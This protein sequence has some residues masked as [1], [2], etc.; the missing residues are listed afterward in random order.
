VTIYVGDQISNFVII[1]LVLGL[2]L[3]RRLLSV[4]RG[5]RCGIA[6]V[7]DTEIVCP[8]TGVKSYD[9][10]F[11]LSVEDK[12]IDVTVK[13]FPLHIYPDA[14][15]AHSKVQALS[16][17][18]NICTI[19]G[20]EVEA[21]VLVVAMKPTKT[22]LSE[23]IA[24][25]QTCPIL[26]QEFCSSLTKTLCNLHAAGVSNSNI[27]PETLT[28]HGNDV[29]YTDFAH[30]IVDTKTNE[31]SLKA[32][33]VDR[34][35]LACTILYT[36]T[37]GNGANGE[38]LIFDELSQATKLGFDDDS[39]FDQIRVGGRELA[40][41][42]RTMVDPDVSIQDLLSRPFFWSRDKTAKFLGEEIGNLLDPAAAKDSKQHPFI[43]ALEERGD[44]ELGGSY[45]ERVKQDG[46]SWAALLDPDYP[47]AEAKSESDTTG[48]GASRAAQ[49][50][51]ADVEH[52]YA[53][54]GKNPSAKQKTAR[55]GHLKSGKNIP[56]ANRRMVGLLKT[57]RNIAFAHRSQHV[58]AGRFDSEEDVLR[59]MLDPFPWLLMAVYQLDREHHIVGSVAEQAF[60]KTS[61]SAATTD[62]ESTS[63]EGSG[64][65]SGKPV[66][67]SG[68]EAVVPKKEKHGKK[69]KGGHGPKAPNQAAEKDKT[70]GMLKEAFAKSQAEVAAKDA[71]LAQLRNTLLSTGQPDQD[72]APAPKKGPEPDLL[73]SIQLTTNDSK[74]VPP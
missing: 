6:Y 42:L 29:Q 43:E 7:K 62:G 66:T 45:D 5:V 32:C 17:V 25:F 36:L 21:G 23:H 54:Y 18:E 49:Q 34:H 69:G 57:I 28:I 35:M 12:P 52:C 46:P 19:Y 39:L 50:A 58:Q 40:D 16:N 20:L 68:D 44:V 15:L 60:V 8:I 65:K 41:L 13:A 11:R 24:E 9:G 71:E 30:A 73:E 33:G 27:R 70:I 63:R 2:E 74:D 55:E 53:V 14:R 38:P 64:K 31:T 37:G 59:Y 4:Y 48:W 10:E 1:L 3:I 67:M 51:P 26:V 22:T 47:L 72:P 56:M 61:D